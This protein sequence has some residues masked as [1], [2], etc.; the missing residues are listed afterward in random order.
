MFSASTDY[1][2]HVRKFHEAIDA[3]V[4][5]EYT[6]L[7]KAAVKRRKKLIQEEYN[8]VIAAFDS[9]DPGSLPHELCDLLY[10]I[11]GT[12][13]EMGLNPAH[14]FRA[15]HDKNMEKVGG[16]KDK[17]GKQ[18]KPK[19]FIP[20]DM[21]YI[22]ALPAPSDTNML[23]SSTMPKGKHRKGAKTNG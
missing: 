9:N 12:F 19:G 5:T 23:Q 11:F 17:D 14:G 7:D 4:N 2:A 6:P 16:P 8:E 21:N 3:P 1:Y 10:V 18:L 13:V 20:V 15:V 22:Y